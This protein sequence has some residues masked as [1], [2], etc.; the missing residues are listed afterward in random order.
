MD[1]RDAVD[2]K[3]RAATYGAQTDV[4]PAEDCG[5]MYAR[6]LANPD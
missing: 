6:D 4:N 5:F 1:S 2:A 3:N